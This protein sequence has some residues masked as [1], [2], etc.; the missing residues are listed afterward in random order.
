[1]AT[2]N[3]AAWPAARTIPEEQAA[4]GAAG[5]WRGPRDGGSGHSG[6]SGGESSDAQEDSECAHTWEEGKITYI[7]AC[8][9]CTCTVHTTWLL[10]HSETNGH[11]ETVA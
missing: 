8:T 1:M 9:T 10:R 7:A 11:Q 4:S 3:T 5:G 2:P 6:S